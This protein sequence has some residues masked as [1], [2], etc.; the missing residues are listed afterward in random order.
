MRRLAPLLA[1]IAL[2]ASLASCRQAGGAAGEGQDSASGQATERE[3]HT[4]RV[5]M[6]EWRIDPSRAE[7]PA[8]KSTIRVVNMGTREHELVLD[9]EGTRVT[10]VKVP[11]GEERVLSAE[12]P[13][14]QYELYCPIEDVKGNH[15]RH[16]MR[17]VL[18]VGK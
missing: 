7:M 5:A 4:L 11:A 9:R 14:G 6:I 3:D 16:G 13:A 2:A 18:A 8:G 17:S 10:S 12:L 1:P 15:R